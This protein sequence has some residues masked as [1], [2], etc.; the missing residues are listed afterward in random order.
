MERQIFPG[1]QE[2]GSA[3]AP[4]AG[5]LESAVERVVSKLIGHMDAAEGSERAMEHVSFAPFEDKYCVSGE[6][7]KNA[8]FTYTKKSPDFLSRDGSSTGSGTAAGGQSVRRAA[9]P[10]LLLGSGHRQQQ[11]SAPSSSSLSAERSGAPRGL[12]SSSIR[13]A[14]QEERKGPIMIPIA[15]V[16][17]YLHILLIPKR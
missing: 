15:Q 9:P 7:R 13:G 2:D 10:S 16:H 4:V 11:A 5:E 1:S 8:L 3:A 6:A 14:R 17:T 12:L